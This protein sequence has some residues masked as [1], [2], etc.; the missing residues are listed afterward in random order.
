MRINS[1]KHRADEKIWGSRTVKL[2]LRLVSSHERGLSK[3]TKSEDVCPKEVFGAL[4]G[5]NWRMSPS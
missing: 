4:E 5:R 3:R 1:E 2:A